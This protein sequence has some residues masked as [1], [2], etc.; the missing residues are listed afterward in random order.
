MTT[1]ITAFAALR[2]RDGFSHPHQEHMKDTLIIAMQVPS[3]HGRID[4]L[5]AMASNSRLYLKRVDL[6][7][8][9]KKRSRFPSCY[10]LRK[11][12]LGKASYILIK[13]KSNSIY[14]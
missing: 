6:R 4:D 12:C 13:L 5:N 11:K 8:R 14:K 9:T 10:Q 3:S 2:P 7:P 1:L